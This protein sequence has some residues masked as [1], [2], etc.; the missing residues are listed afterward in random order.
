[1]E[2][3][4]AIGRVLNAVGITDNQIDLVGRILSLEDDKDRVHSVDLHYNTIGYDGLSA[5]IFLLKDFQ[6]LSEFRG[7]LSTH[8]LPAERTWVEEG[9]YFLGSDSI[10]SEFCVPQ[11]YPKR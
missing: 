7:Y 1:M 9:H 2:R 10:K 3:D 4:K 8:E 6:N 11:F 5:E